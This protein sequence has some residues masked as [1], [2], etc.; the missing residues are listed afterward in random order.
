MNLWNHLILLS[1]LLLSNQSVFNGSLGCSSGTAWNQL[2][3]LKYKASAEMFWLKSSF[4]AVGY[5]G[6]SIT[7]TIKRL[8]ELL[9][10]VQ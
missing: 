9:D 5:R 2:A 7:P 6:K 1:H 4:F 10:T 8:Y 3:K